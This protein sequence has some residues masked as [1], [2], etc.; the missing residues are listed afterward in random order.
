MS[1]RATGIGGG[2]KLCHRV[3]VW[4]S[5][6]A[7]PYL[8]WTFSKRIQPPLFSSSHGS[9]QVNI[10]Q[11]CIQ[12]YFSSML[13]GGKENL[14]FRK[15]RAGAGSLKWMSFIDQSDFELATPRRRVML[16][17]W[18]IWLDALIGSCTWKI[19]FS[20]RLKNAWRRWKYHNSA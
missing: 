18:G 11:F 4:P 9:I 6:P 2:F 3:S 15:S 8:S 12:S 19:K 17:I 1:N 16:A 7:K 20:S 13:P 14:P 5:R 10:L